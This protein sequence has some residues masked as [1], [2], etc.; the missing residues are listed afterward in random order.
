MSTQSKLIVGHGAVARHSNFIKEYNKKHGKDA[1][2]ILVEVTTFK[3]S[4]FNKADNS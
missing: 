3:T 4:S 2:G 1:Q